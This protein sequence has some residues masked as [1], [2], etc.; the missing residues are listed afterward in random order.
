MRLLSIRLL[1]LN[2]LRGTHE[3]RFDRPP[4]AGC[5]VFLIAGPTGAGKSTILDALTLALYGRAARYGRASPEEMMSRHTAESLAEVEFESGG[6]A[7]RA[8]WRMRRARGRSSGKLQP[9]ERRLVS[10]ADERPLAEKAADV[11]MEI[12]ALTGLDY[13]RFLRSVLLAQGQFESFL[14]AKPTERA[15]LLER[16]TGTEI[17]STLSQRAHSEHAA[18]QQEVERLRF[19]I[20]TKPLLSKEARTI[21]EQALSAAEAAAVEGASQSE[22]GTFGVR[23]DRARRG[24]APR[25]HRSWRGGRSVR[26]NCHR[27]GRTTRRSHRVRCGGR[28]GS[29]ACL[30]RARRA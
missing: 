21:E 29:A 12:E 18:R 20:A 19:E 2:S 27:D 1:N 16:I 25:S 13:D 8:V 22:R 10:L 17:Y 15:E 28:G 24:G 11:E 5:G 3:V 9:V 30:C 6:Q 23:G 7:Y 4:L 26:Q 14:E